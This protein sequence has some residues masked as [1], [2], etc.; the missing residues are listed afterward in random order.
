MELVGNIFLYTLNKM[1]TTFLKNQIKNYSLNTPNIEVCGL[2]YQ[3]KLNTLNIKVCKNISEKPESH[4]I[5]SP[6]D[7]LNVSLSNK[8]FGLFHSH[9]NDN[10]DF[11]ELDKL[12]AE[13]YNLYFVLYNL[14]YNIFKEYFP[15]KKYNNKYI[16]REFIIGKQDCFTLVKDYYN[17]ELNI[18]LTDT[19]ERNEEWYKRNKNIFFD[20]WNNNKEFLE[21]GGF[22]KIKKYD[23]LV[24]QYPKNPTP[25]HVILYLGNDLILH[26]QYNR[27]STVE[28]LNNNIIKQT[29]YILRHKNL[30]N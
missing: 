8:I 21:I 6:R 17:N 1:L 24:I 10:V 16:G 28:L 13:Q 18:K 2:I 11:S 19:I 9:I 27:K 20:F 4:F 30:S 3:S 7:Y 12:T 29:K 23:C 5:I 25:S 22:N 26:Q 14:K 15:T